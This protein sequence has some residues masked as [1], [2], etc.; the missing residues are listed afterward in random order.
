M[1][2]WSNRR[3]KNCKYNA[4]VGLRAS[5][6]VCRSSL[7]GAALRR[8]GHAYTDR[9]PQSRTRIKRISR[10]VAVKKNDG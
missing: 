2:I 10:N 3:I 7:K 1:R 9:S 4:F 5:G 6:G 8:R